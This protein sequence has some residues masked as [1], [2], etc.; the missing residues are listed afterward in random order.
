MRTLKRPH[1]F[2]RLSDCHSTKEAFGVFKSE[3]H[4]MFQIQGLVAVAAMRSCI[5]SI[6]Q[7]AHQPVL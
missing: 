3:P 6:T 2:R 7:A 4:S 1:F 5:L